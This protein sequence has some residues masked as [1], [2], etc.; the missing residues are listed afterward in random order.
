MSYSATGL[1]PILGAWGEESTDM[2]ECSYSIRY[3][4]TRPSACMG[5]GGRLAPCTDSESKF[6]FHDSHPAL[7]PQLGRQQR[8]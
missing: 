3:L 6:G 1:A 7:R 2:S 4:S 8:S 5:E